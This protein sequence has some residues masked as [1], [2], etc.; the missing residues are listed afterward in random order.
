VPSAQALNEQ[1]CA[2]LDG[3]QFASVSMRTA[4]AE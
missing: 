1:Y 4:D 3:E 2:A